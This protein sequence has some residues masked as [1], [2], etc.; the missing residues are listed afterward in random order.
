MQRLRVLIA[1]DNH[2]MADSLRILLEIWG[3]ETRV[4][5]DGQQAFD[6]TLAFRPHVAL[7][8]FSMPKLHGG[9]V[10]ARLRQASGTDGVV[11]VATTANDPEDP[12]VA[13]YNGHFDHYLRKPF[14]VEQLER[15]LL[16]C[17]ARVRPD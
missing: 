8:D 6:T 11:L 17:A 2:D 12:L 9:E 15:L 14:N 16:A 4:V 10:A 3:Y 1:D 7:L 13:P 5:R